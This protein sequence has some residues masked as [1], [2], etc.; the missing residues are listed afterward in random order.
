MCFW[1]WGS[2]SQVPPEHCHC[3][4]YH[5]GERSTWGVSSQPGFQTTKAFQLLG[6][7]CEDRGWCQWKGYWGG[8]CRFHYW[9]HG[10]CDAVRISVGSLFKYHFNSKNVQGYPQSKIHCPGLDILRKDPSLVPAADMTAPSEEVNEGEPGD[11]DGKS[12][13]N[14]GRRGQPKL[15]P[16]PSANE[17]KVP[18]VKTPEQEAKQVPSLI[19]SSIQYMCRMIYLRRCPKPVHSSWSSK[20]SLL[21]FSWSFSFFKQ[22]IDFTNK[23]GTWSFRA[24]V[25]PATQ[26][27]TCISYF[28]IASPMRPDALRTAIVADLEAHNQKIVAARSELEAGHIW[29]LGLCY[30]PIAKRLL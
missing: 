3:R 6:L 25:C 12:K 14:K 9:W 5:P 29:K 30:H 17:N 8:S 22:D 18:K 19:Y 4:W 7:N 11:G 23:V 27:C 28:S 21:Y 26:S 13:P 24:M 16:A 2:P 20:V 10:Y 1:I 15:K